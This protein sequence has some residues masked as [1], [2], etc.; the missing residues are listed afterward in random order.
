M[1]KNKEL[2]K[3]TAII[4]IGKICTQFLSIF[5]LP[6]YTSV[7]STE[8]YGVV[9]LLSTYQQLICYVAFFQ[10]EQALFRFLIEV[11]KEEQKI[12]SIITSTI[13]FALFQMCVL[14]LIFHFF[15]NFENLVWL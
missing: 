2:V 14:A 3:N 7:L 1:N 4:S 13:V 10:I 5:L 11:R 9:D 8:E 12:K 6:L 15:I